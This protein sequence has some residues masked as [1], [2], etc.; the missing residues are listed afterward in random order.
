MLILHT[1]KLIEICGILF[2]NFDGNDEYN[3]NLQSIDKE[4]GGRK[5]NGT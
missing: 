4:K 5:R 3:K 1:D 2:H